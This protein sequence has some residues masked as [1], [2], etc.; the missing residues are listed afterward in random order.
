[1]SV[2]CKVGS[3]T[4]TE[5]RLNINNKSIQYNINDNAS[6]KKEKLARKKLTLFVVA[7][8]IFLFL[9]IMF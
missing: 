6:F 4:R 5:N 8:M 3:I 1:M 7:L 9:F 2:N